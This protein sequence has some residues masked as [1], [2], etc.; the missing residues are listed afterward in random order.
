MEQSGFKDLKVWQKAVELVDDVYVL[1]SGLPKHEQYAITSQMTRS[2]ISISS[3]IAEGWGRHSKADFA[4]FL[5]IAF[6]L[7]CELETQII[8]CSRQYKDLDYGSCM[9]I[10]EEIKKML[11]SLIKYQRAE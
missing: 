9:L 5:C 10:L 4:R 8:I 2:A 1:V 7:A 6:G 3:N 11:F